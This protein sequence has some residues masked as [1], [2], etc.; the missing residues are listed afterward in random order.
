MG[1]TTIAW[2]ASRQLVARLLPLIVSADAWVWVARPEGSERAVQ[3]LNV[4]GVQ[5]LVRALQAA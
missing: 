4:D 2:D 5:A 3:T 1:K